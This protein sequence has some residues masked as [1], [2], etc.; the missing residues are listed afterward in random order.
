MTY[1]QLILLIVYKKQ[2]ILRSGIMV[3]FG[4]GVFAA[5]VF[6]QTQ[7]NLNV[8]QISWS[9]AHSWNSYKPSVD[10]FQHFNAV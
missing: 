5:S 7:L 3:H 1:A 10:Q 9:D 6:A 8:M 4:Y 2:K